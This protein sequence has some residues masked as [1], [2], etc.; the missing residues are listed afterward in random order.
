MAFLETPDRVLKRLQQ[1]EDKELPS[2]PS[3]QHDDIDFDSMSGVESLGEEQLQ[4]HQPSLL[5]DDFHNDMATP[6]PL[7]KVMVPPPSST[8]TGTTHSSAD[9]FSTAS[10]SPFPPIDSS[11]KEGTPSP[12]ASTAARTSTPQSHQA[13]SISHSIR[14]STTD[15]TAI[16]SRSSRHERTRSGTG[17]LGNST[18]ASRSARWQTPGEM[19]GS[20][21]GDEIAEG[22]KL[23]AEKSIPLNDL[24][25]VNSYSEPLP[26]LPSLT[27]PPEE[28]PVTRRL[29]SGNVLF[30]RPRRRGPSATLQQLEAVLET[31]SDPSTPVTPNV[32][33]SQTSVVTALP[34][35]QNER[36]PSL[37]RSEISGTD[38]SEAASTPEGPVRNI[39]MVTPRPDAHQE[40][41]ITGEYQ[42][43]IESADGDH[44]EHPTWEYNQG[45]EFTTQ[46]DED[47]SAGPSHYQSPHKM[48][49]TYSPAKQ[50][51]TPSIAHFS[52]P[53]T[54]RG[55]PFRHNSSETASA[56]STILYDITDSVQ[57]TPFG[58]FTPS[59]AGMTSKTS[60]ISTPRA[61]L[62]D[63]ERRKSHVLAVLG[64]SSG[65]PSR[66]LRPHI[67]GTPHP[68]R[69]VSTA[70]HN[71]SIAEEG[72]DIAS[73]QRSLRRAITPGM[74]SRMTNEQSVDQSFVSVA[75]SADLTSDK[76]ASH[77]HNRLSRGNTSF[78]TIL[79][80]TSHPPPGGGSLKGLSDQ[81]ADGI[82]IHK[83]LNA[84]NKQ[85]LETN[86]DLA[87][88]AEAWRDEADR[89]RGI[90]E[91]H[92][93]DVE[94]VDILAGLNAASTSANLS[95]QLP[96]WP[97]KSP[98]SRN[99]TKG[100]HP[101]LISQL[102]ALSGRRGSSPHAQASTSAQ[103]LLE[104]LTPE[105]YAAVMQEMAEKLESLEEGLNEKDQIIAE[106]KDQLEHARQAGSPEQ[107][108][109]I[110]EI[111]KLSAQLEEAEQAGI[112]LHAEFSAKTEQHAQRFGEI[113]SGFE[114]QVKALEKDLGDARLEVD[115]L[116]S[117]KSRLEK[118][119]SMEGNAQEEEL[120]KRITELE[121]E[122]HQTTTNN[123][124]QPTEV[125]NLKRH[126][127]KML[128][129]KE[130]LMHRV[131]DA[132]TEIEE[133]RARIAE[134]EG[135]ENGVGAE[136]LEAIKGELK[137]ACEAQTVAED[138]LERLEQEM[139]T[140]RKTISEQETELDQQHEHIEEL[141]KVVTSL[142]A[143]LAVV[144]D[145]S[146][147][148]E[149]VE[150]ELRQV[151]QE[152]Q[153][154]NEALSNKESEIEMLKGRLEVA[155]I[156]T[157]AIRT[158]QRRSTSP[159]ST[160]TPT[161]K[162]PR[163]DNSSSD[164]D[165]LVAAMEER[166][167]EAYR[168]IGRLKHELNATPH[169]KSAVEV[170]DARIQALEREKAA[171][172][173]RLASGSRS[174]TMSATPVPAGV[175]D[176]GSPFKRPTPLL[177][178]A[179]ASL[180]TPKTPGPLAELSWLQTTIGDAN[181]PILQAQLEYLQKELQDANNQLDHNFSRLEAAGLGGVALAEKLAAA[182]ERIGE[183]EDE[184]RT[185]VQRNKASL[186]LV[187]A[188]KEERER[189]NEGRMRKALEAVHSQME[190]LKS[191]IS[192][193]RSRLQRDNGR[194][195][196]LVS[197]MRLKSQAEVESFRAEMGRMAEKAEGDLK[198]TRDD[199]SRVIRERD[200]LKRD[201]ESSRTQ[202]AQLE[203]DIAKEQ[204]AYE[205]LS[206]RNAQVTQSAASQAELAQK[207]QMVESLQTSL[208]DAQR[209]SEDLRN[210]LSQRTRTLE[211]TKSRLAKL[212][213][214]RAHVMQDLEEF[215]R[216]LQTQRAESKEFGKQ[217]AAL[218]M[219]QN[220]TS[221]KH[222]AE[223]RALER[224][225]KEAR[226]S[227]RRTFRELDDVKRR[228]DDVE[229]WR[230]SHEC[231]T[232]LSQ[233]LIDQKTHF[234]TQSRSLASQ[235]RYLKAKFT[236]ESTFRN[237]LALQKRYLLLLVGGMSLDQQS[238]L[239]A[240][241]QMGYPVAESESPRPR[242][243]F[244]AVALAVC[245]IIRA[246]NTAD[247]WK[248]ERELKMTIGSSGLGSG[249][250]RRVSART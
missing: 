65:P 194:L 144:H 14:T 102:S 125:E 154:V 224:E 40:Y 20:F 66:I 190:E 179:I 134:L 69:R 222:Q 18:H 184:I 41:E 127:A 80:P 246:R 158:S 93:I 150:E 72:S 186:A 112:S 227:E 61:P 170:R 168:E 37:S 132:E 85:L 169:R 27:A 152:L 231:E 139:A 120:R 165:S 50:A 51:I 62:D 210:T 212:Q 189:D 245:S 240:M 167:D 209:E 111:D 99:S 247:Q 77:L 204:R 54:I 198:A 223:L 92:G 82:K 68:L 164:Q 243:T 203:R 10:G 180:R 58:P 98:S 64:S 35:P 49:D 159:A 109:L 239:R 185:L 17:S 76:R 183:L 192:N 59:P 31:P 176:A 207:A 8:V 71:E 225:L 39:S 4:Y 237:A 53:G 141:N 11:P 221:D 97:S 218:K 173:D 191:D 166:L 9:S 250:R 115:R 13:R 202:I 181:E 214:E 107:Q 146:R 217:L 241:A 149:E 103:D 32:G 34:I 113:C 90:L 88:E 81:R 29:S 7:R 12:Y 147:V 174:M 193:E 157:Q 211:D 16:T 75:S 229:N 84:M 38:V 26:E 121:R 117:D 208:R 5:V 22:M 249:E 235:I 153:K 108:E 30:E 226:D 177:H 118:M 156:A 219:E 36:I 100:D 171:L 201:L 175:Q 55:Q 148:N 91:E 230:M 199:L 161:T 89:L 163:I 206:R 160:A 25:G 136:D 187:S 151:Q 43:E 79:L 178:K 95:Q 70:P 1:L 131:E 213:N 200:N 143:D 220:N 52:T 244:K 197:E 162:K 172:A 86:A 188:Q 133:L 238:T 232:G 205:S 106:L 63:A 242:R 140:A 105:E 2:L 116:S 142:E 78:P 47:V 42:Y 101:E 56:P 19:S 123:S 48:M 130:G 3:F 57:N 216:D 87:R 24:S 21:S 155:N 196:N 83:H 45:N 135:Q 15:R 119:S 73:S 94:D 182:E 67:R 60:D 126:S 104:G 145:T 122:L 236:R 74:T 215:E 96:D 124:K 195:Q 23:G 28:T 137:A 233:A 6:H 33:S 129:E 138:E 114:E 128:E 234:K 228:Y 248:K 46:E 44:G 110:D